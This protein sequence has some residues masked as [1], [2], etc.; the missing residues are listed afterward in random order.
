MNKNK[1]ITATK[2][3]D[4]SPKPQIRHIVS[5]NYLDTLSIQ[6]AFQ[7]VIEHKIYNQFEQWK[8]E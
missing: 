2:S 3:V 8:G 4:K 5:N 7:E 1:I 6:T